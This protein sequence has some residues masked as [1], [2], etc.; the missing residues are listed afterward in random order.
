MLQIYSYQPHSSRQMA[1]PEMQH[2]RHRTQRSSVASRSRFVQQQ[3]ASPD[4][5]PSIFAVPC[6][7]KL[8]PFYLPFSPIPDEAY[9]PSE[10]ALRVTR[11]GRAKV[12]AGGDTNKM[13]VYLKLKSRFSGTTRNPLMSPPQT[14]EIKHGCEF[15]APLWRDQLK[16]SIHCSVGLYLVVFPWCEVV[17]GL[18]VQ[19]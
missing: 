13:S 5:P 12:A 8:T 7:I 1:R 10:K 16:D 6:N 3:L 18:Q 19:A 4:F 9:A 15:A 2:G 11:S 14:V 17:G